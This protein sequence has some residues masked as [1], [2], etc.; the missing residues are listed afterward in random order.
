MIDPEDLRRQLD[1]AYAALQDLDDDL[2][3]GRL[4]AADH[5]Q[6]KTRSERHA[7]A[8]L[9]RLREAERPAARGAV[10]R[11]PAAGAPLGTRLRSPLAL[12]VG[13][14]AL[15]LFGVVL[16]VL[17]ARFTGDDPGAVTGLSPA[18][19]G[20]GMAAGFGTMPPGAGGMPPAGM[21]P[22]QAAGSGPPPSPALEA[23]AKDVEVE[24][25]PV[26]T[27]L[28]FSN[29]A[30]DEGHV[31]AAIWGYKRVLEREPKNVEAIAQIGVILAKGDHMEAALRRL[32]EA[33]ALDPKYAPAHWTRA[34]VLFEGKQ[35][36]PAAIASLETYLKI[37]PK[38]ADAER[39][40]TMLADARKLAASG[41]GAPAGAA[42]ESTK[43]AR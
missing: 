16:G 40:R 8:L 31:P 13:A 21:P 2:A 32:D 19:G 7:A 30:L 11:A 34:Q 41:P 23:L 5:A 38:S 15:L 27:L 43:P 25:P 24:N 18:G 39:A 6:L 22:G 42:T 9:A 14:V 26:A 20:A 33:I 17:V 12:T 37:A 36:Y 3:A 10:G 29:L 4:S 28:R 1:A 35:D